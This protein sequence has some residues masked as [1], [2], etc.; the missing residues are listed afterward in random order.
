MSVLLIQPTFNELE[1]RQ[2]LL[3]D[4]KT[5]TYNHA[6]GGTISFTCERWENWYRRWIASNSND[7]F[8]RYL[9][10]DGI[11]EFVGEVAYHKDKVTNRYICNVL[12]MDKY[13]HQGYGKK[14]LL[15]LLDVA[16]KNGIDVLYDEI[17]FDNSSIQLFLNVGFD[18]ESE[19]EEFVTVYKRL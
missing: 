16:K 5:M 7:Y 1:F 2:Q 13:R 3:A 4:K 14:G 8:Y 15:A 9:Y 6:Y 10:D 11:H 18:I 17:A 19:N 12:V